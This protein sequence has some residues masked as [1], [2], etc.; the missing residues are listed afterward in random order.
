LG[1][2]EFVLSQTAE[3]G[4]NIYVADLDATKA[5]DRVYSPCKI[6]Q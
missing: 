1:L 2:K 5:F 3:H 4:S 6:I